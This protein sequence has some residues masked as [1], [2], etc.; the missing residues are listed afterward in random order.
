MVRIGTRAVIS[1]DGKPMLATHWDGYPASLGRDLL[2]SDK[3]VKAV[4]EVAKAHTI[5]SA[6]ASLLDTLNGER[7]R[8][9]A[10]KHQLTVQEIKAGIRRGNVISADDCEIAD[11][12]LHRDLAEFQYDIRGKTVFFRPLDGWWPE[13]LKH[14]AEFKRLGLKAIAGRREELPVPG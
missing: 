5:D 2:N 11:I 9:L 7:I 1:V 13:A 4:I 8:Q 3:S 14:T 12:G 10:E 6:D